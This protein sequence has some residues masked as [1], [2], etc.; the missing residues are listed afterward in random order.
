MKQHQESD[1]AAPGNAGELAINGPLADR[2]D[3]LHGRLGVRG[4]VVLAQLPLTITV[5]LVVAAAALFS[6]A[7]LASDM[8]RA[9][10]LAHAAIF[11]ACLAVPW[12]KLPPGASA[13]IAILDCVAIG[14]TRE[15]GGA[16]F[17]VLSLLLVFP[18]MWLSVRRHRHMLF[19]AVV[20]VVLSTVLPTAVAGSA[21][22]PAAMIRM[23]FLPLVM[24]AIAVTA[25]AAAGIVLRQRQRLLQSEHELAQT[26]AENV[27][28][29]RLLDAVLAA[30][31]IGVWVVDAEGRTVLTNKAMQADPALAALAETAGLGGLYLAD[32]SS[33]VPPHLSP[34]SRAVDGSTILDELYWAGHPSDQA[35]QRAYSV[36][37]HGIP[38]AEG[39][40]GG[41]VLTFVDVTRLISALAAKDNFVAT[42]SHE[43]RT[44]LTSILGYLELVLDEPGHEEIQAE[45]LV[46]QRNAEHLLGL[47][48]DLIA[49]ASE[50]MELSLEDTDLAKLLAEVVDSTI[51]KAAMTGIE[52]VLDV[53][54]PLPARVDRN[55]IR[56]VFGNLL[57]NSI[58]YSNE[59]GRITALARRNGAE[60]VCSIT[61]SG[62]G[63]SAE[64]QEQ[65]FTKFFR[66]ARSR[67]TAIPGAG[68]GLPVSKTIIEA[69]GGSIGLDSTPGAGTTATLILPAP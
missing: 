6:P 36:S 5:C 51:P 25:Y 63:M 27:R 39:K 46:V 2:I 26:L 33:P 20:G 40:D 61:D 24:S 35:Q 15:A 16:A 11:A 41:S 18:V 43:L 14:F 44:P 12:E 45:L 52:L 8:F 30:V 55:R 64:E 68:L 3:A 22:T 49:V 58:K 38:A 54:Q 65:A 31:G 37:A 29:Q 59:G 53:E 4:R 19:L 67:E 34:V 32:R 21:Q 48:N 50:R 69:H 13:V 42:V 60:L 1:R 23:L 57:S 47:V 66:S 9:A 28:R 7:T 62:V 17:N 56:Q 10:L